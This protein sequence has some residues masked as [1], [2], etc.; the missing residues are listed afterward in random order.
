M[1]IESFKPITAQV[2]SARQIMGSKPIFKEGGI[3]TMMDRLRFDFLTDMLETKVTS[4]K[5]GDTQLALGTLQMPTM[6]NLFD[7]EPA[8]EVFWQSKE[9][10]A[11]LN[12]KI[13]HCGLVRLNPDWDVDLDD[14]A[15]DDEEDEENLLDADDMTA[16]MTE[17]NVLKYRLD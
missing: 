4:V 17:Q 13:S 2:P 1:Q 11:E 6:K 5:N 3:R 9:G 16:A 14:D 10:A 15:E 8:E 7:A 12:R